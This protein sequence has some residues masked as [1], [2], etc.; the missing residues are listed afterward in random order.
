MIVSILFL[1][2]AV[3][4]HVH[5]DALFRKPKRKSLSV[6]NSGQ[7]KNEHGLLSSTQPSGKQL[8]P[9][10]TVHILTQC[11]L[12]ILPILIMAA[13]SHIV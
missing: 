13:V 2:V 10:P 3:L 11:E 12:R 1:F 8:L 5:P 7:G 4:C 6:Q 9:P